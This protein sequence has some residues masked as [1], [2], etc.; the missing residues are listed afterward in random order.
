MSNTKTHPMTFADLTPGTVVLYNDAANVDLKFTVVC[1]EADNFGEW[2]EVENE[3]GDIERM[4]AHTPIGQ[5]WTVAPQKPAL[6]E[7]A[8]L[9]MYLEYLSRTNQDK[10]VRHIA[11]VID[12]RS[13]ILETLE[14]HFD[15]PC[16]DTTADVRL[17]SQ[18][19]A[20][21]LLLTMRNA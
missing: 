16:R 19:M 17:A 15:E 8:L 3:N 4:K 10:R 18:I 1:L 12:D 21:G 14:Y 5:R 13:T 7:M 11:A 9:N 20:K 6:H 2:V